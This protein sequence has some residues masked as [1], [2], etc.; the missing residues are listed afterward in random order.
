MNLVILLYSCAFDSYF[1]SP[2][3]FVINASS[4]VMRLSGVGRS[5]GFEDQQLSYNDE[6]KQNDLF[7]TFQMAFN[8]SSH[9]S[10]L[11]F[12]WCFIVHEK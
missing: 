2:F 1:L 11:Q 12:T 6:G 10:L 7:I 4:D 8:F 5:E 9:Q 3:S